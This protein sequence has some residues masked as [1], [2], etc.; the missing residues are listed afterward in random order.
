M[1]G[2]ERKV[3]EVL[4]RGGKI[5]LTARRIRIFLEREGVICTSGEV[6]SALFRLRREGKVVRASRRKVRPLWRLAT[7][8]G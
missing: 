7:F 5:G 3:E 1:T 8:G 2:L 6:V 4:R